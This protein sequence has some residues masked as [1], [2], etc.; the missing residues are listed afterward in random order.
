MT[1]HGYAIS[2]IAAYG[3]DLRAHSLFPGANRLHFCTHMGHGCVAELRGAT[4]DVDWLETDRPK[5]E[6]EK[7]RGKQSSDYYHFVVVGIVVKLNETW[8]HVTAVRMQIVKLKLQRLAVWRDKRHYL[9]Q[10][11]P[12]SC[13]VTIVAHENWF[14]F[15]KTWSNLA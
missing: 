6:Q 4:L 14:H 12:P 9:D 11:P 7:W 13:R 3:G 2:P 8:A 1:T 5:G 10:V 15:Y